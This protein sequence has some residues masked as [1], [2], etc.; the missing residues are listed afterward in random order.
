[1]RRLGG[2]SLNNFAPA[3][4][5]RRALRRA[6][7]ATLTGV[8]GRPT[9][10][11]AVET[12]AGTPSMVKCSTNWII[13]AHGDQSDGQH[14]NS[15]QYSHCL[16]PIAKFEGKSLILSFKSFRSIFSAFVAF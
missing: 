14:R 2:A 7:P 5:Q 9:A 16:S 12:K 3:A 6:T 10:A 15:P 4:A 11:F 8:R 13:A 1:M